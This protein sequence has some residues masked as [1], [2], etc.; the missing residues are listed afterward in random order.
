MVDRSTAERDFVEFLRDFVELERDFVESPC[1]HAGYIGYPRSTVWYTVHFHT[2]LSTPTTMTPP[3]QQ[4]QRWFP[5][6]SNPTLMNEYI[7]KLGFATHS[8]HFVDVFSTE[9]WALEMIPQPVAA[10]LMLYPLTE[11]QL[12]CETEQETDTTLQQQQ[13]TDT[14]DVW[15]TK[16]RIGNACGTIGLLHSLLNTPPSLLS[17][18]LL[19]DSWLAQFQADT[20]TSDPIQ[21]AERLESDTAIAQLHDAATSSTHNQTGRGQLEDTVVTHFVAFIAVNN[22]LYALDG[23]K[24]GPVAYGPTSSSRLL[25]DACRVIREQY[26]QRDPTELRFTILALAPRVEDA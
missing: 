10:V 1:S 12:K 2:V 25:P 19:P 11:Q 18:S 20:S 13:Q 23:R 7:Q 14:K 4:Q 16:Q 6:E 3:E 22:V 26:M 15:F 5:L 17:S 8:Y 21:R 24:N 9:D